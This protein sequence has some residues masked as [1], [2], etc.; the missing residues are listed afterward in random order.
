MGIHVFIVVQ[1]LS[2]LGAHFG[3]A[4]V[5]CIKTSD[6]ALLR[7]KKSVCETLIARFPETLSMPK[8][9]SNPEKA[10]SNFGVNSLVAL[11]IQQ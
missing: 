8:E 3:I 6:K 2:G 9:D 11:G 5:T 1:E 7:S 10:L 4:R